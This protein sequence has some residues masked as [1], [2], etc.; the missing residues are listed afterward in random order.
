MPERGLVRPVGGKVT[1]V[2]SNFWT[3]LAVTDYNIVQ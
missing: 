3:E 2:Q 1:D